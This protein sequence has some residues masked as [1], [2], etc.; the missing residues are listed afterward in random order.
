MNMNFEEVPIAPNP[1]CLVCGGGGIE[2]VGEI[3]YTDSC[4]IA[5]S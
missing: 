1:D 5:S 2:S 4:A 3:E